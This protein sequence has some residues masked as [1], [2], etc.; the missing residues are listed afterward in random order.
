MNNLPNSWIKKPLGEVCQFTKGKKPQN[1]G[2]LN[3]ERIVPYINIKAFETGVHEQFAESG[4]YPEC[5]KEDVLIVWDGARSG[6]VGRGAVGYIGSTIAKCKSDV[7]T[8]DFLFYFLKSKYSYINSRTKGVGIPHVDPGVINSIGISVPPTHE[9]HRI[10][11]KIEELFSELDKG[12][13]SLT[14]AREQLKGYRQALLKHAFG[15]KLTEQWRAKHADQLETADQLLARIKKERE[16]RYQEQLAEWEK[17][18]EEWEARGKKDDRPAKPQKLKKIQQLSKAEIEP[19]PVLPN[20]WGWT[21][22]GELVSGKTRSMQSGPFGSN[23]KHSEFTSQGVLVIGIDNVLEGKFSLGSQNRITKKKF[24]ELEKYQARPRDLLVTVM[25]SLGRTCVVPENLEDAIIT[26]HV[27]RI[28][29]EEKLLSTEFYNLLLQ[30]HTVSRK[31]MFENAQGQTRPGLNST[32]LREL[33]VPLCDLSEQQEIVSLL[34][35]KLVEL[36]R[37]E[38]SIDSEIRKTNAVRQSILKKAFSGEL[39]HQD[40][41]DEPASELLARIKAEREEAQQQAKRKPR[42]TKKKKEV[43][44]MA[45]LMEVMKNAKDWMSAQEVFR[46]CGIADGAETDAIEKIYEE[47]RGYVK[48]SK[49]SVERR[50]EEDWLR[51][52]QGA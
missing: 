49:I 32:I 18:I 17:A 40:P 9:Q 10:V 28:T 2:T 29:M 39:V 26:K 25:A 1:S 24:E 45:D 23:L 50:G 48:E 36:D 42:K 27:Y 37:V 19:L 52:T 41:N 43:I 5:S 11:A 44:T 46:K 30:S 38:Y 8:D 35:D 14:T 13:E 20:S 34:S 51:L 3:N 33:P 6:L 21:T 47:L 15:G 7:I 31:R 16:N 4:D 22:L 12:V